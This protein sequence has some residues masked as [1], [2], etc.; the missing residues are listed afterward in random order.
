ME[1]IVIGIV[2]GIASGKSLVSRRLSELG[3]E[4]LDADRIGHQV[5][6]HPEVQRA[7]RGRWGDRVF[8]ADGQVDRGRLAAIVFGDPPGNREELDYLE[9]LTHPEIRQCLRETMDRI[10]RADAG[11]VVVLDAA[12]LLEAGW[13]RFCDKIL[14]VEAP[15]SV[16]L[17]RAKQRGWTEAGFAAREAAQTSVET[18]RERA[19]IVIDNS[20]TPEHTYN[21]LETMWRALASG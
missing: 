19:D 15:R 12:L 16:R 14:F 11:A 4:V 18:K 7:I 9:Q 6:R 5:L 1:M 8:D 2:G 3:A 10:A 17:D 13:D 20:S 21:Q